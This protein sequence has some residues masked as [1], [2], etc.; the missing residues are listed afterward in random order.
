MGWELQRL[1]LPF[2]PSSREQLVQSCAAVYSITTYVE[3]EVHAECNW[4]LPQI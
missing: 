1:S 2:S 4:A 3:R